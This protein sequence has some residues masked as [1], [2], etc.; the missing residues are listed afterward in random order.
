MASKGMLFFIIALL[1]A[2][3]LTSKIGPETTLSVIDSGADSKSEK[4]SSEDTNNSNG[5]LAVPKRSGW[6][7]LQMA[8]LLVFS[9]VAVIMALV[10]CG[11]DTQ[12][13]SLLDAHRH[14]TKVRRIGEQPPVKENETP[15]QP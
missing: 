4:S 5:E 10:L 2:S 3:A 15:A 13:T 7:I 9:V 14:S 8:V 11:V 1:C 12:K 6:A